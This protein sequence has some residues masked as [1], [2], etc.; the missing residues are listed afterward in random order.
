[1]AR[2]RAARPARPGRGARPGG[3]ARQARRRAARH[4]Q[5]RHQ[6]RAAAPRTCSGRSGTPPAWPGR[7]SRP[8]RR[9][10]RPARPR[11]GTWTRCW[12]C[13]TR[14][15]TSPTACRL[16]RPACSP[17][18]C[19]GRRSSATPW[20]S[21]PSGRTASASSPRTG[22]RAWSGTSWWSRASRR[23]PGPT[24]G[25]ADPCSARTSSPRW[26]TLASP[27]RRDLVTGPASGSART[28]T[29]PC[30]PPSC[31]P[32]NAGC[33]TWRSPGRG[34]GSSSPRRAARTPTSGRPGS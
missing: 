34:G 6:D 10:A 31:W 14:P 27:R 23:R 3:R 17:T 21:G 26:C 28:W 25:C 12:P 1:M 22:P 7:G 5:G 20:P 13:S 19:P 11:T 24:C 4:G 9:A 2:R 15:R 16:A 18:P 32:R 8:A 33:S 29:P 30:W